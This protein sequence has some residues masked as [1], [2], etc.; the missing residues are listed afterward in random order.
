MTD[1]KLPEAG[2]GLTGED[3]PDPSLVSLDGLFEQFPGPV[4]VVAQNGLPIGANSKSAALVQA[5]RSGARFELNDAVES[6]LA[7]KVSQI[8]PL[9]LGDDGQ[10][11]EFTLAID[12][13]VL[14]WADGTAALLLG[15]DVTLER[16]LRQ[17]LIE[18]RELYKALVLIGNDF[19]WETDE[20]GRFTFLV[21]DTVLGYAADEL[22]GRTAPEV[23][24]PRDA[25]NPFATELEVLRKDVVCCDAS[26]QAVR[27]S[28]ISRALYHADGSCRGARGVC[29]V[30][31]R[32]ESTE[33]D[34]IAMTG[35]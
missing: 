1:S 12:L 8:N 2:R 33:T 32:A 14:P 28:L 18:S 23:I 31:G 20:K 30:V 16:S 17:A 25:G 19:A 11:Q 6:A 21:P 26:G 29:R 7:G 10:D 35:G 15:R 22:L 27:L 3:Q 13:L 5:F 4:L 24:G 34:R 9:V